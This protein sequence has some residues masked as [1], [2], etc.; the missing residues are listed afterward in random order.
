VKFLYIH[1]D[2]W[3][4]RPLVRE[5]APHGQDNNCQTGTNTW[6]WAPGGARHQNRLTDR[7]SVA[8][9][10]WIWL[11]RFI[12]DWAFGLKTVLNSTLL[13]VNFCGWLD[14]SVFLGLTVSVCW[15]KLSSAVSV[16]I[17]ILVLFHAVLLTS[18]GFPWFLYYFSCSP[19][20][21]V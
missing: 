19:T 3:Q 17:S 8:M 15:S 16:Q 21:A 20:L 7:P 14:R 10:L 5:G 1:S 13:P 12:H 6:S 18:G 4:S 11:Y 2:K 9:W